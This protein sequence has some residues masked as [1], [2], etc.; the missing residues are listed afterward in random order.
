MKGLAVSSRAWAVILLVAAG[1]AL[2]SWAY[3][4]S[5]QDDKTA[6]R[7]TL[8]VAAA[9]SGGDTEGFARAYQPREFVFPDDHGPHSDYKQ[10]WWYFTGNV[11]TVSG[12]HF[13]FQLTFFRIALAPFTERR[14]SAW[15]TNEV[16]MAHFTV[17]DIEG[18]RFYSFERFSRAAAGL[19]GASS[20]PLRV[21]LEDWSAEI[22]SP[23]DP[24]RAELASRLR[25]AEGSVKIDLSLS[26]AKPIVLQGERGL[27]R[28]SA[29][30]GN[31]SY[32]YSATRL[33]TKGSI[34][35]EGRRYQ[36]SG[37]SWM[38]REWSTS[39]LDKGQIGWDWFALQFTDGRELMFY[40]LRRRDGSVDRFSGGTLVD[41]DGSARSLSV[42]DVEIDVR[43]Y[44]QSPAT[45]VRYP[46]RWQVRIPGEGLELEIGPHLPGQELDLSV[47]Y[48]EGA[49]GVTGSARGVPISG[50][51]Y[52]ELTGY[53]SS[54]ADE[55]ATSGPR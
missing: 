37:L 23:A 35:I 33:D 29:T 32:Y 50:N 13:G 20:S 17:S 34:E 47:R 49:V 14:S 10:E 27:S 54:P 12:R 48:W 41:A 28:K 31:A 52:V 26:S 15:A 19:A 7:T 16:Y 40:R 22:G 3:F 51:G 4:E 45:G 42:R 30:P 43:A 1:A 2:V 21:W 6:T 36:V 11:D 5:G 18:G 38:D 53:G 39:A 8:S 55:H 24:A 9:L 46:S 25:A 44:W